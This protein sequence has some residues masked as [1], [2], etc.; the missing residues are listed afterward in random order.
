[1]VVVVEFEEPRGCCSVRS[2]SLAIVADVP[3]LA[4]KHYSLPQQAAAAVVQQI[5]FA[6]VQQEASTTAGCD[7]SCRRR[8]RRP[9]DNQLCRPG[10]AALTV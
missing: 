3:A 9:L 2:N 10:R 1:M 6:V 5:S 8:R 4:L 7:L